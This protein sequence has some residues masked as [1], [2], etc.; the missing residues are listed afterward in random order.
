MKRKSNKAFTLLEIMIAM[1]IFATVM[2]AI[3]SSWT[4][5]VR[6][7]EAGKKAAQAAQRSRM[8][9]RTIEDA[10]LTTQLFMENAQHYSFIADTSDPKFAYLSLT[11]QLPATFPGSGLFGDETVRRV[12]FYVETDTE[13]SRNLMMT[14]NP[15]L[16]VTN[17][18]V[19]AYP[20]LLARDVN[21]FVLEFWDTQLND[22]TDELLTT[23]QLPKMVRVSL[24]V[25]QPENSRNPEIASRVVALPSI[26]VPPDVQR[27]LLPAGGGV[28]IG[29]AGGVGS[30][31]SQG[32][33]RGGGQGT[34]RGSDG[35]GSK[36]GGRG[37][38][39]TPGSGNFRPQ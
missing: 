17:A 34:P 24:E 27:P 26:A 28:G 13:G 39:S 23:N 21:L 16:L 32:L 37:R 30:G 12:T 6:G 2:I 31:G 8:A 9:I 33:P 5:I 38:G 35:Q 10:L 3:Y 25:G 7:T 18:D 29:G 15:F 19:S 22:W 1:A 14:Q 11:A 20:I 36:G 4:A